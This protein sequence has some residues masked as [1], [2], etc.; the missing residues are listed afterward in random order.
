MQLDVSKLIDDGKWTRY[1]KFLVA[2][3]ALTVILDGI[4]NQLLGLTVKAIADEWGRE[5]K[6]FA[7]AQMMSPF[8]MMIGGA[9]GGWLGDRIGRRRSLLFSVLAFAL[10]TYA[11][12]FAQDLTTL[13][14]C[15]CI[16]G[17]GLGGAMPNATALSSEY[18]PRRFR[19]LAVTLTIV[20]IPVGSMLASFISGHLP[21]GFG[22]RSLFLGGGLVPAAIGMLLFML[23]PESPRFLASQPA[24]WPE[25]AAL[26]RRFGLDVASGAT[27]VGEPRQT[28]SRGSVA[29]VFGRAHLH[30]TIALCCSFFF[31]LLVNYLAFMVLPGTLE[32]YGNFSRASAGNAMA[33]WSLGGI[34]GAL[35]GGSIL[36]YFGSRFPM[37]AISAASVIFALILSVTQLNSSEIVMALFVLLGASINAVQTTMYAL[38]AHIYPTEIRGSGIGVAVAIGRVGNMIAPYVG[39]RALELGGTK[40]YFLTFGIGM[41][42][43]LGALALITR[44]IERNPKPEELLHFEIAPSE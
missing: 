42:V 22:W 44:H 16:A 34:I 36:H 41:I 43:V 27:F 35:T 1:Q 5:Q 19:P 20:C 13:S 30:D 15:R 32:K 8:G 17:L 9:L 14:V 10:P 40:T 2:C 23:L 21:A 39:Y 6:D 24:R 7:T 29:A 3:T 38:A 4:D 28:T 11:I 33:W 37:L 18:V 26:L 12:Y 31:C 25:L